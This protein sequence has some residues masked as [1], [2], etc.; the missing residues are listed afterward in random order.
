MD[1]IAKR[2]EAYKLKESVTYKKIIE[3]IEEKFD[4]KVRSEDIAA[5][6]W[7]LG[8]AA[9]TGALNVVEETKHPRKQPKPGKVEAI[10]DALRNFEVI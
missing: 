4:S 1:T 3:Y 7:G 8:E 9:P 10:N 5:V 2:M 6:K